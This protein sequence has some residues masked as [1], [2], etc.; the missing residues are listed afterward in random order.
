M[1]VDISI[2][3]K[4]NLKCKYCFYSNEMAALSDLSTEDWKFIIRKLGEAKVMRITLTGGEVFTRPDIFEIID[5]IIENRMRYSI[6]TNG[7]LIDEKTVSAFYVGKRRLRL[8]SI[9]V[10]IDGSCPEVHNLSR[11]GSF[12]RAINGLKLL[13]KEGFPATV[14][15]TISR[16]NMEDLENIAELLLDDIGM[17]SIT[18]NEASPIGAGC[19]YESEVALDHVDTLRV[20]LQLE[21]LQEKYPGRI[22]ANAGPFAKLRMYREMENARQ[23]GQLTNRWKMGFLSSC[24]GVF[25]KLGILHDGSIVPCSMLHDLT[26]GNMLTD[27]ILGLWKNSPVIRQVRERYVVPL[28]EIRACANCEWVQYCN[29]GCPGVTQ[30]IQKTL[31]DPNWRGCYRNFLKANGI[32]SICDAVVRSGEPE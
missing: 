17:P 4:C 31:L 18:N 29:G 19:T 23:N 28:T 22:T 5:S 9:Q 2:T 6:L 32:R 25:N 27:D 11:P 14:R 16:H 21:K 26:M 20:G 8:D 3:G 1:S 15:V 24:G 13:R 30:Q 12:D 7:T 10:S